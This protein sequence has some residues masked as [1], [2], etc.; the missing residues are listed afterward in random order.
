[1][2][3]LLNDSHGSSY[4]VSAFWLWPQVVY[5]LPCSFDVNGP[6]KPA[7]RMSAFHEKAVK[8]FRKFISHSSG[9]VGSCFHPDSVYRSMF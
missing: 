4:L 2:T 3:K 8:L 9:A 1:V 6:P 7:R 5:F